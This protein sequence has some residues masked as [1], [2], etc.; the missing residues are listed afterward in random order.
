MAG[1]GTDI[2]LSHGV[3]ERGGLAVILSERHD[4]A[5]STGSWPAEARARAIAGS[6]IRPVAGGRAAGPAAHASV[7]PTLLSVALQ[8]SGWRLRFVV[9]CRG[10]PN[11]DIA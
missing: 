4:A 8:I 3:D 11:G 1:R 2:K 5:A 6:F 9:C 10:G 7:R